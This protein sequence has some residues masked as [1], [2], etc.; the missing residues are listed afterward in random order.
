MRHHLFRCLLT[1]ACGLS[2][3]AGCATG[4]SNSQPQAAPAAYSRQVAQFYPLA[5]GHK[6]T[7]KG[8]II[9]IATERTVQITGQQ[10]GFYLDNSGGA[11]KIDNYGLI[12]NNGRY[13]LR[14]PLS[15]GTTWMSVP[16]VSAVERY[17]IIG[18]GATVTTPAGTFHACLVVKS[19]SKLSGGNTL[20][21][22]TTFAPK[23]GII[24]IQT[25]LQ[26]PQ[27]NIQQTDLL[28]TDFSTY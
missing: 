27:G 28:L 3:T 25:Y 24:R 9:G 18:E 15:K 2:L 14:G 12:D 8:S 20:I 11:L 17:E 21:N 6:W 7:Y 19:T 16:T 1:M 22:I 23:T 5:I 10:D 13:L 4:T 26:N